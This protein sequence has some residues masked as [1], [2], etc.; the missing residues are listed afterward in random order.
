MATT[1]EQLASAVEGIN[2]AP[3]PSPK[4]ESTAPK[5]GLIRLGT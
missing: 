2:I 1:P 4:L 3:V 5:E